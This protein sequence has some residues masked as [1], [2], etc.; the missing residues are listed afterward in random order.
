VLQSTKVWTTATRAEK[1]A[2]YEYTLASFLL[3]NDG[4][5]RFFFSYT[6]GDSTVDRPWND[7]ALGGASGPYAKTSGVYQRSF[8][9]GRVLVNPT[10]AS[11]TVALGGTFRTLEG[12]I[13]TSV[14]L[15]PNSG[16][17]LLN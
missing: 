3:G 4:R 13:V 17:I 11:V 10:T 14:T 2:W 6:P 9:A 5:S 1:D 16:K 15:P 7:L 12:E 8:S